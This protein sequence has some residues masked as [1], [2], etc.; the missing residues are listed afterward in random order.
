MEVNEIKLNGR[1]YCL[2]DWFIGIFIS[3][4]FA[5]WWNCV[6]I[7]FATIV[8]APTNQFGTTTTNQQYV[9]ISRHTNSYAIFSAHSFQI[10]ADW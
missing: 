8:V 2:T 9:Y 3:W 4:Q 5:C 1:T 7:I 6:V 10:H